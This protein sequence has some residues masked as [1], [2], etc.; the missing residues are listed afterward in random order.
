MI[1]RTLIVEDEK[2]TRD[3]LTKLIPIINPQF[4]IIG[5]VNNGV[6]AIHLLENLNIDLLITDI[7]MPQMDGIQ[8]STIIKEKFPNVIVIFISGFSEFEF[9][10]QALRNGVFEYLLKPINNDELAQTLERVSKVIDTNQ[11][12]KDFSAKPETIISD[13]KVINMAIEYIGQNYSKQI[14][15]ADTAT[16]CGVSSSYLSSLFHSE[17]GE[18]YTKYLTRLRMEEA[19]R[20]LEKMPKLHISQIAENV[21]Y[22]SDKHF[23]K[24]F[25]QFFKVTPSEYR[26][27]KL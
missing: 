4:Q 2:I 16:Y 26:L 24:V 18:S 14:S 21:G 12:Q 3:F 19:A 23:F 6:E 17:M 7:C 27:K 11:S 1:I 20:C 8:I 15:L 10:H 13:K 25:K 22:A 9:A 5:S